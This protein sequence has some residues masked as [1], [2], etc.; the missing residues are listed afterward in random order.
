M[1]NK[2][3][4]TNSCL[5]LA[6]GL[7]T[8]IDLGSIFSSVDLVDTG[9]ELDSHI[10]L[11]YA[12]ENIIPKEN[13]LNDINLI[14]GDSEYNKLIN[15]IC[16]SE[17]IFNVLDLFE[18]DS[19]ENDIDF[20]VLKMKKDS[21][22]YKTLKLINKGLRSKYSVSSDFSDYNPHITLAKLRPG[23]VDNYLSSKSLNAILKDSKIDFEDL[24]ISYGDTGEEDRKQYFLTQFKN[25]DRYFR[26]ENLKRN[27]KELLI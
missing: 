13:M 22:I 8:P 15:D 12:K 1:E 18:L 4:T 7:Y 2:I 21:D 27:N 24:M 17:N 10:T 14:L 6:V 16:K 26:L 20:L 11:L 9:L 3:L 19:F 23:T 25:I 5:M